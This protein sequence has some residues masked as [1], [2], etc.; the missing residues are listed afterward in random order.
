MHL[1]FIISEKKGDDFANLRNH[2]HNERLKLIEQF[3]K[4]RKF[5]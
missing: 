1:Y 3:Q 5:D 4:G 2:R